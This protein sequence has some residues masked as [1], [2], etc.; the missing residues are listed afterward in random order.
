MK[1]SINWLRE[2]LKTDASDEIICSLLTEIGLEVSDV[3]DFESIKGGLKGILVGK[4]ESCEKHPN[5]DKLKI[6]KVNLGDKKTV[7]IICGAPNIDANKTVLVAPVGSI[8]YFG[9]KEIKIDKVKLRGIYSEGMICSEK[10]LNIS[11]DNKGIMIL[12]E[13][14]K[15]GTNASDII[16]IQKVAPINRIM[17][18]EKLY[19]LNITTL[20][21]KIIHI[22]INQDASPKI[23][24]NNE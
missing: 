8:L 2:Y 22:G 1:I 9:E 13:N 11:E 10:E 15:P 3:Y 19:L 7:Q 14:H 21:K 24:N 23:T 12:N 17:K 20:N 18:L 16:K 5:A 4:V 6:T